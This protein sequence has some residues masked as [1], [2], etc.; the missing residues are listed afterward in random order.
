MSLVMLPGGWVH[1]RAITGQDESVISGVDLPNALLLIDGLLL[2][3]PGALLAPGAA[4]TLTSAARDRVLAAIFTMT[5]G[6]LVKATT[7]CSAC[8]HPFDMSFDLTD[9]ANS[10]PLADTPPDGVY[11]TADGISFRLPTGADE[12]AVIGL[13]PER[14]RFELLNRCIEHG[15]VESP[16]AAGALE[17]AMEAVAPLLSLE[18]TAYCPECGAARAIAFDMQTHLLTRLVSEQA[19]LAGEVHTLALTYR[20]GLNEILALSRVQRHR[21]LALIELEANR[22]ATRGTLVGGRRRTG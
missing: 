14:A 20:W 2:V 11:A 3:Q 21:Y 5:Y 18:L 9:L 12:L 16:E 17:A 19:R 22:A 6:A 7:H 8:G 4:A 13:P 15:S 10:L 1:L